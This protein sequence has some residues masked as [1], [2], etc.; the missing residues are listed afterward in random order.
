MTRTDIPIGARVVIRYRRCD[1]STPP[2]TDVIGELLGYDPLTVRKADGE[3]VLVPRDR[4]V[5][6]KALGP[7]PERR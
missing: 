6:M 1:G 2:L 4:V 3:S 5:A 7:R